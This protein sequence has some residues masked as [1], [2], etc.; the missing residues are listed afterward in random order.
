MEQDQLLALKEKNHQLTMQAMPYDD[1][2]EKITEARRAKHDVRHHIML[3]QKYLADGRSDELGDYLRRYSA[4]LPDDTLI[5]FCQNAAANAVLLYFAQQAKNENIDYLVKAD[6]PADTFL[7]DPDLSVLFG[8]LIE[9]TLEACRAELGDRKIAIRAALTGGTLCVTVD[10]TF[11]G[12][13][14]RTP[15]GE[16]LSAK[17]LGAG[18]GTRSVKSIAEHYGGV[19]RL[20][21]KDGM[22]YASVLCR[23]PGP[24]APPNAHPSVG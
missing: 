14:R 8:N 23:D 21:S 24:S 6:I 4:S 10:N 22:F 1:L 12:A 19:C 17:H 2:Q 20:E 15:G 11:T 5:R 7:P 3:M 18:L 16:P 9:N 13:L